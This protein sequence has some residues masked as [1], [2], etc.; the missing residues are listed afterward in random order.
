[1]RRDEMRCDTVLLNAE[2][3]LKRLPTGQVDIPTIP[4]CWYCTSTMYISTCTYVDYVHEYILHWNAVHMY[5]E[6]I[7]SRYSV[8]YVPEYISSMYLYSVVLSKCTCGLAA[9]TP[10]RLSMAND[11]RKYSSLSTFFFFFMMMSSEISLSVHPRLV[12]S[13]S[14]DHGI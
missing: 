1:M 4:C 12:S 2:H 8:Q 10:T 14:L 13:I 6:Y 5:S 3:F 11:S 9:D 7:R